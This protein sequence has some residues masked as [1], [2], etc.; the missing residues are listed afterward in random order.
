MKLESLIDLIKNL[1][2]KDLEWESY[3]N[4]VKKILKIKK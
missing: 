1:Q 3:C 4:W 2:K